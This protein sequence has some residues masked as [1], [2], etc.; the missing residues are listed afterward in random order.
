M[1]KNEFLRED[2]KKSSRKLI[3]DLTSLII[4]IFILITGIFLS[5]QKFAE[6]IGYNPRY[7]ESP[8][9]ILKHSIGKY[10]VG[11]PIFN[12]IVILIT[13]FTNPFDRLVQEAISQAIIP[14]TI[15]AVIAI[16]TW[17]VIS[18]L[19]SKGLRNLYL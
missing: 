10:P 6:M 14:G 3:Y 5:T 13:M 18:V 2:P 8:I 16:L 12:P 7:C 17:L 4:P 19:R 11:Y 15:S 9:Y 1:A